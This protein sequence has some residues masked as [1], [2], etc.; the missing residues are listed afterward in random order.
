MSKKIKLKF[1]SPWDSAETNNARVLYNWGELPEC[2][3]LTHGND[4]DY[5]IVINHSSEMYTS[6]REKN[7]AVT[8]EPTWSPNSL[9]NLNDYCKYIITCDKKIKGDNVDYTYPF[10]FSHDSR[11]NSHTDNLYGPTVEDYLNN[12]SFPDNID[13][14]D[15]P[16]KMS[17]IVA[18]HGTLGGMSQHELSN[19][20]IRENL[21]LNIL[22]SDLDIDIYGKGWS[23]ND[24][25]Y[26]GAPPLK[27]T[28]LKD[29]KYSICMENSSEDLY[30]SEKF[31]D[32]FLNNC[33][34]IY[35]GCLN[36]KDAYNKD[37]FITFEP[38]SDTV[39]K[40]LK[41]IMDSPISWR[42]EAIKECKNHYFTKYNLLN[43]LEKL[44]KNFQE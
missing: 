41:K 21:L 11:N 15:Y 19:Y 42:L 4:Y 10:L 32:V 36:I 12:D 17:F 3:E 26:K 18:N 23:I 14:P 9:K 28:A 34:P 38:E 40:E 30:I 43:Y 20:S 25:R 29:Y 2:F 6:P 44:I 24:S 33:V 37:A 16:K 27:T 22:N 8:M 7:I 35:Y 13:C 39:I 31:F 5:L 1:S